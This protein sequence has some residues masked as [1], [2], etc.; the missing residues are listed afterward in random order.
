[1]FPVGG[2]VARQRPSGLP[3]LFPEPL[4]I[5]V[6]RAAN[7]CWPCSRH[8]S[9]P[10]AQLGLLQVSA[11]PVRTTPNKETL[12]PSLCPVLVGI[13]HGGC[14][15]LGTIILCD[16]LLTGHLAFSTNKN[17]EIKPTFPFPVVTPIGV[18]PALSRQA[19]SVALPPYTLDT[20]PPLTW[21]DTKLAAWGFNWFIL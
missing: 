2:A 17:V 15:Y 5:T 6:T 9:H 18:G 16:C 20:D 8:T 4:K 12:A 1:M 13:I 21:L 14:G 10:K 3:C 7:Q 19:A 11:H